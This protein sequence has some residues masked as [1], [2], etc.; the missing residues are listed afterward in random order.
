MASFTTP[1]AHDPVV[2]PREQE[3][4]D[5]LPL[6]SGF[7]T[8]EDQQRLLKEFNQKTIPSLHWPAHR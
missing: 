4:A 6:P 2:H 5:K 3:L 7:R 1:L 8:V